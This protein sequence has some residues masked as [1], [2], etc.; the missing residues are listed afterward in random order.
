MIDGPPLLRHRHRRKPNPGA[1][2]SR[3]HNC[4]HSL[5]HLLHPARTAMAPRL[6]LGRAPSVP[7]GRVTGCRIAGK[8]SGT[9]RKRMRAGRPRSRVGLLPS[10]LLLKAAR[11]GLPG[12]CPTLHSPLTRDVS[13]KIE[14]GILG[15]IVVAK[16]FPL[17]LAAQKGDRLA[18][19]GGTLRST[20]EVPA[21]LTTSTSLESNTWEIP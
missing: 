21:P 2:A 6:C 10:L 18:V 1:R 12:R 4:W 3:P 13:L 8:L 15:K 11:A 5:G 7:A 19:I 20:F 16:L 14:T 9:Q 17:V